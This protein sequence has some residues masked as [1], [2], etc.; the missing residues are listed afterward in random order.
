M[1]AVAAIKRKY[2][3]RGGGGGQRPV[4]VDEQAATS[5]RADSD[6][7]NHGSDAK[8]V[9]D[10]ATTSHAPMEQDTTDGRCRRLHGGGLVCSSADNERQ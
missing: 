7:S 2:A 8:I 6:M 10:S 9:A 4:S 5:S 3:L 1:T